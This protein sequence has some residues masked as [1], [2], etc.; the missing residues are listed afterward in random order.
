MVN[1]IKLNIH[2]NIRLLILSDLRTSCALCSEPFE[3]TGQTVTE[4]GLRGLQAACS[5]RKD[6]KQFQVGQLLH[7]KCRNVYCN[8]KN[9][10]RTLKIKSTDEPSK[11]TTLRSK[12]PKISLAD[13]C[14]FCGVRVSGP[15]DRCL[16]RTWSM[17]RT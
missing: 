2:V 14:L 11:V 12:Q 7:R 17:V 8:P 13:H 15:D 4:K 3:E 10:E 1:N 9:I 6:N 16:D 5:L